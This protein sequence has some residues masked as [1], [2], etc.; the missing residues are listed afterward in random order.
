MNFIQLLKE[1]ALEPEET[2]APNPM[3][4]DSLLTPLGYG[5]K[6]IQFDL[7]CRK[8]AHLFTFLSHMMPSSYCARSAYMNPMTTLTFCV[9]ILSSI[10]V[11]KNLWKERRKFL[12]TPI[13]EINLRRRDR[14][15]KTCRSLSLLKR[16]PISLVLASAFRKKRMVKSGF[17]FTLLMRAGSL[18]ILFFSRVHIL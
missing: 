17:T 7:F 15:M 16:K 5:T 9:W 18:C 3:V 11:M 2:A 1:L 4:T 6:V 12:I 13:L 10:K 14:I 8:L